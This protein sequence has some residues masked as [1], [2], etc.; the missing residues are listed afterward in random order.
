MYYL[1]VFAAR[2]EQEL[3]ALCFNLFQSTDLCCQF[4]RSVRRQVTRSTNEA[5]P[6]FLA[7]EHKATSGRR[8]FSSATRPCA[9]ESNEGAWTTKGKTRTA[10]G[11][12]SYHHDGMDGKGRVLAWR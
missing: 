2:E 5:E 11:K 6:T 9:H 7:T 3:A 8:E 12:Q 4:C 10:A 1:N